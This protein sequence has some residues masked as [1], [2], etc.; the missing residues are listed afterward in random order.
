MVDMLEAVRDFHLEAMNEAIERMKPEM[1]AASEA[2]HRMKDH[3]D[4][5]IRIW[6]ARWS[7][8]LSLPIW[9]IYARLIFIT[10]R[11]H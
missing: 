10:L 8:A 7:L 3:D 4:P 2:A 9:S 6:T 1:M 5:S 11:K